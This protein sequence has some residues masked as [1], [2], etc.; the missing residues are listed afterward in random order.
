[1][2][3]RP[4]RAGGD[5][6]APGLARE[7]SSRNVIAA[8]GHRWRPRCLT[9]SSLG[10]GSSADTDGS[11]FLTRSP[12]PR[13]LGTRRL[14]RILRLYSN[15]DADVSLRLPWA[16]SHGISCPILRPSSLLVARD[17]PRDD[18]RTY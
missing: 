13:R 4:G 17:L 2:R 10:R 12:G 8:L 7:R 16:T 6:R 11:G 5:D 14:S 1:M 9:Q 18:Y 3:G 15:P